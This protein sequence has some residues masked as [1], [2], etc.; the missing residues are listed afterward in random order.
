VIS[1]ACLFNLEKPGPLSLAC[2]ALRESETIGYASKLFDGNNGVMVPVKYEK[3]SQGKNDGL[4]T[5]TNFIKYLD[6]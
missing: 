2:P 4:R 1:F 6:I 5:A 3:V